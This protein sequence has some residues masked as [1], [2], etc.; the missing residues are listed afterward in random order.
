MGSLAFVLRVMGGHRRFLSLEVIRPDLQFKKIILTAVFSKDD[1]KVRA[2]A[3][4][5]GF[6]KE[7]DL[8]LIMG[9]MVKTL[10]NEK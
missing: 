6:Y 9:K 5:A 7:V 2:K 4:R 1:E 3:K 8:A 10:V